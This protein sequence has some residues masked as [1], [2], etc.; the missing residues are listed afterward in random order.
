MDQQ[1]QHQQLMQQ[2]QQMQ[3][4]QQM[5]MGMA[6]S[7]MPHLQNPG[8]QHQQL[9]PIQLAKHE[10]QHHV[11]D[12]GTHPNNG[13]AAHFHQQ[14]DYPDEQGGG[15]PNDPSSITRKILLEDE[16]RRFSFMQAN[17]QSPQRPMMT[18]TPQ[19]AM[20]APTG[21][22]TMAPS[23]AM[24]YQTMNSR[25]LV[26]QG[27]NPAAMPPQIYFQAHPGAP[28]QTG[29]MQPGGGHMM[30][31]QMMM[32]PPQ[33]MMAPSHQMMLPMPGQ[34]DPATIGPFYAAP[35]LQ[36][37]HQQQQTMPS[38]IDHAG[39]GEMSSRGGEVEDQQR[40][41]SPSPEMPIR[42]LSAYNFFFSDEREKILLA[43]K[44]Q[45]PP[46]EDADVKKAR[47][48]GQHLEKDRTKRRPHRKTHGTIG[49]TT[50]SKLIG[51]RW[52]ALEDEKKQYY[53]DIAAM[54]M[55]RY[56]KCVAEYNNERLSKR[57][58]R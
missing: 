36:Q 54:D 51:K 28:Q 41:R 47:L 25:F 26:P 37:H 39:G 5:G 4:M 17:A 18:Q 29:M 38:I 22:A 50:L 55:D 49:F 57:T 2:Q 46:E 53:R 43:D 13:G 3:Q 19:Y 21:F 42:P 10:E 27:F 33:M 56:Q 45:E 8:M 16:K 32:A 48:L 7:P 20:A 14:G 44:G 31:P 6:F 15:D 1:Q 40:K 58:R 35:T 9:Q 30:M 24:H 12:L 52:K 11:E 23:Q 34:F